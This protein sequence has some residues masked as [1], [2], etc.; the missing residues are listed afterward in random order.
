M[1]VTKIRVLGGTWEGAAVH[2][3]GQ[4][5]VRGCAT[6]RGWMGREEGKWC[7]E[8]GNSGHGDVQRWGDGAAGEAKK[9]TPP[10]HGIGQRRRGGHGICYTYVANN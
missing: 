2:E 6:A 4:F 3:R 7:T 9:I 1:K 5:G 10:L 8:E